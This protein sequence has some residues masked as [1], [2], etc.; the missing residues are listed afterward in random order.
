NPPPA[1]AAPSS[2]E[3]SEDVA[4][5]ANAPPHVP[6][7]EVEGQRAQGPRCEHV[8][9]AEESAI[10]RKGTLLARAPG[11]AELTTEGRRKE[12]GG[13]GAVEPSEDLRHGPGQETERREVIEVG[14]GH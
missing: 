14:A 11:Q 3:Q 5:V 8:G 2:E 9:D 1:S 6:E 4:A 7:I 13:H 12:S 10:E